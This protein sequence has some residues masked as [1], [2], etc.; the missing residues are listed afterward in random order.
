MHA[1]RPALLT[2]DVERG[3]VVPLEQIDHLGLAGALA[4]EPRE[5]LVD[6]DL[7]EGLLLGHRLGREDVGED[8]AEAGVVVAVGANDVPGVGSHVERV[9]AV[10]RLARPAVAAHLLHAVRVVDGQDL[11][12]H[13]HNGAVLHVQGEHALGREA[14]DLVAGVRDPRCGPQLGAGEFAQRVQE[15]VVQD[16]AYQ[17]YDDLGSGVV[18]A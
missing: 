5:Q 8:T 7:D 11:G 10:L 6:V 13:A 14:R 9:L 1:F 12:R 17:I 3:P 15:Q 2:Y 18:S 4:L 16:E